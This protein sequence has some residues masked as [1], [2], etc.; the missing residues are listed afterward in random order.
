MWKPL[1]PCL[2][3]MSLVLAICLGTAGGAV[4]A[5]SPA[6]AQTAGET[7]RALA[8]LAEILG[9]LS[10][11]EALCEHDQRSRDDMQAVLGSEELSAIR[12]SVLIDAFNRG[13][14]TVATTHHRC[15]PTSERLI[16]RHHQRGAA[17]VASL[18]GD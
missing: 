4:G 18:L 1:S 9:A 11:L 13:F 6:H 10:H 12:Q 14:R 3:A 15:T 16:A 7:D 8:R 17:I 2:R 5:S